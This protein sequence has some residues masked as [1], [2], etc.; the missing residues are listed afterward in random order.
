MPLVQ[1]PNDAESRE[2]LNITPAWESVN[3]NAAD[4]DAV[5]FGGEP[6]ITGAGRPEAARELATK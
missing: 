4:D 2:H 1:A 6:V 5:G 3:V